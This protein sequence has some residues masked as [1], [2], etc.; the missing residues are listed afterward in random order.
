MQSCRLR[1]T[2]N[3]IEMKLSS[4]LMAYTSGRGRAWEH[5]RAQRS[6]ELEQEHIPWR[7]AAAQAGGCVPGVVPWLPTG[8]PL[9]QPC[10]LWGA[11]AAQRP[12][13]LLL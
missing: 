2:R 10:A 8:Q 5:P 9:S 6:A 4:E 11:Q 1:G 7:Q 12:G 3:S 13:D